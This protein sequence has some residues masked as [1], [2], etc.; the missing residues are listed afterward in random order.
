MLWE[1]MNVDCVWGKKGSR[2]KNNEDAALTICS[3]SYR[4]WYKILSV[5]ASLREK[6]E[7]FQRR[8]RRVNIK[9]ENSSILLL[10]IHE[11]HSV[12]GTS[13]KM[14]NMFIWKKKEH[15]YQKR[16]MYIVLGLF[17]HFVSENANILQCTDDFSFLKSGLGNKLNIPVRKHTCQQSAVVTSSRATWTKWSTSSQQTA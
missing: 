10:L 1:R 5:N 13:P 16:T 6:E 9:K 7:T 3:F 17:P 11:S 14:W 8:I 4:I 2:I 12:K 15:L